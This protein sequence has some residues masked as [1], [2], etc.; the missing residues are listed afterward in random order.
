VEPVPEYARELMLELF[1][2]GCAYCDE[3]AET[4]DH[5]IPVSKGGKT[6]PANIL[7]ACVRCNSSK[8]DRDLDEWLDATD[9]TMN[10]R[11]IEHLS[12]HG[13]FDG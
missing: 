2:G 3:P 4:W 10:V 11:A 6:E 7:P 12:H 1:D 8:R 5:V 9:R 13:A